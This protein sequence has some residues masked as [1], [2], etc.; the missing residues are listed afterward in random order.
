M[1]DE[2]RALWRAVKQLGG[3]IPPHITN[4][5]GSSSNSHSHSQSLSLPSSQGQRTISHS[6]SS[7]NL[8]DD[9][10]R[11]VD[12]EDDEPGSGG[13]GGGSS[14]PDAFGG[15]NM[16][17]TMGAPSPLSLAGPSPSLHSH[18]PS[19]HAHSPSPHPPSPS[20][21]W[22][23]WAETEIS[24]ERRR[25][26]KLVNVVR[27][28]IEHVNVNPGAGVN[29]GSGQGGA[30][31]GTNGGEGGEGVLSMLLQDLHAL[32]LDISSHPSSPSISPHPMHPSQLQGHSPN[33]F[34]TSPT[35]P[36]PFPPLHGPTPH[37]HSAARAGLPTLTIPTAPAY[38]LH[39]PSSSPTAADLPAS[40]FG[41]RNFGTRA[42]SHSSQPSITLTPDDESDSRGDCKRARMDGAGGAEGNSGAGIGGVGMGGDLDMT[43]D[44]EE[45][46][47]LHTP[48]SLT[49]AP[50]SRPRSDSAWASGGDGGMP[51]NPNAG[52][53]TAG[54]GVV[55]WGRGRSGSGY[56]R[57]MFFLLVCLLYTRYPPVDPPSAFSEHATCCRHQS[58]PKLAP[59]VHVLY[60]LAYS[61]PAPSYPTFCNLV[62]NSSIRIEHLGKA[63]SPR[64][65]CYL[66]VEQQSAE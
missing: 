34:V 51:G 48:V 61:I 65:S 33:I 17:T 30:G 25:V 63:V 50:C 11:D 45:D 26:D 60:L 12:W 6:R 54:G 46:S 16:Q 23:R 31:L 5:L 7:S 38:A 2:N 42:H 22:R 37:S 56:G 41:Q 36:S 39:T 43:T 47:K 52:G 64:A 27:A 20:E 19:L 40:C 62:S 15:L 28:Y 14:G 57:A 59:A 13:P 53:G 32:S 4:T 55:G 10:D 9:T 1:R 44:S 8:G 24:R 66:H 49:G 58:R 21:E 35:S 18:S 3:R 29:A